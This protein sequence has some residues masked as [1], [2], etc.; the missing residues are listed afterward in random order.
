MTTLTLYHNPRCSKSRQA[1]ALLDE[2]GVSYQTRLYLKEPLSAAEISTL[3]GQLDG[4][5]SDLIRTQE[6]DYAAAGL[7]AD[8]DMQSIATALASYPKLMQR[9]LLS[10]GKQARIGRPPERILE[11][12]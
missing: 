11:L 7:S 4:P 9:P 2:A 12:I 5:A 3:L 8:S 6:A 10:D 1:Q